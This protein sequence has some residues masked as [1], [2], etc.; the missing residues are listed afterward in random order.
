VRI[1]AAFGAGSSKLYFRVEELLRQL[2]N[3]N[4]HDIANMSFS[5]AQRA[6]RADHIRWTA[7]TPS[8]VCVGDAAFEQAVK[9]LPP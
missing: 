8:S 9:D 1:V 7:A 3:P 2:S 5:V 4:L 6:R